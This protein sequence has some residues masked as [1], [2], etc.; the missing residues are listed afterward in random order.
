MTMLASKEEDLK[1]L[2]AD[3]DVATLYTAIK[4]SQQKDKPDS[5]ASYREL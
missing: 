5:L 1:L 2:L 4:D 3:D